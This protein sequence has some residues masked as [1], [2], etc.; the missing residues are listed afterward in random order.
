[1]FAVSQEMARRGY[2]TEIMIPGLT[3]LVACFLLLVSFVGAPL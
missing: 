3:V 1:M 2:L